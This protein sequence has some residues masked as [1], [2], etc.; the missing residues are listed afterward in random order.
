MIAESSPTTVTI[1]DAKNQ[2]TVIATSEIDEMEQ[3]PLSLMPEK[4]LDP[5]SVQEIR[6]LFS[7][8]QSNPPPTPE[9]K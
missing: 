3:S 6:D 8:L 7:Y 9:K 4:L 5:L 1:L 2:R